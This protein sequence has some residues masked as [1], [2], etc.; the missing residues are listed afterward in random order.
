MK[1]IETKNWKCEVVGCRC[2]RQTLLLE[3][4]W[5]KNR[6]ELRGHHAPYCFDHEV[7]MVP[8]SIDEFNAR[9]TPQ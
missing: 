5:D 2:L 4:I 6:R 1:V 3:I 8:C 9:M 7:K